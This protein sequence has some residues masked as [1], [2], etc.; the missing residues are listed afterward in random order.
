MR[1]LLHLSR[2]GGC[3]SKGMMYIED[4]GMLLDHSS[5]PSI[6]TAHISKDLFSCDLNGWTKH[7]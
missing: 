3:S 2:V 5:S 1:C 4:A 7:L 6:R